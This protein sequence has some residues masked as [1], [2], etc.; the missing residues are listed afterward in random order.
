M[1]FQVTIHDDDIPMLE[2]LFNLQGD[3]WKWSEKLRQLIDDGLQYN[4]AGMLTEVEP[5]WKKA[6]EKTKGQTNGEN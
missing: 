1:K 2:R 3:N 4:N 6:V 5:G